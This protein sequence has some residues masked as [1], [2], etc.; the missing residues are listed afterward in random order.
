[1]LRCWSFCIYF[2]MYATTHFMI[3]EYVHITRMKMCW[4][5]WTCLGTI[6]QYRCFN[7][8]TNNCKW[9][10]RCAMHRG[11]LANVTD[12]VLTFGWL[13]ADFTYHFRVTK[14][15]PV[16]QPW[17]IWVI[18]SHKYTGTDY[19]NATKQQRM[20]IPGHTL[21]LVFSQ[22]DHA[23]HG[24]ISQNHLAYSPTERGF[25][26]VICDHH[27]HLL[28]ISCFFSMC[29]NVTRVFINF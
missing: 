12:A 13:S 10:I 21:H 27:C 28:N 22:G 17:R 19:I 5:N 26:S 9:P 18:I 6:T 1:M 24:D 25:H 16:K 11:S 3:T 4:S 2:W 23:G 14:A 8:K 15:V 29:C 7:E 20:H